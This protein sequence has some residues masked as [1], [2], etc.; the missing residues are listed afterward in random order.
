MFDEQLMKTFTYVKAGKWV[1]CE[2]S[3]HCV[4]AQLT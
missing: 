2:L 3:E 4:V 1:I